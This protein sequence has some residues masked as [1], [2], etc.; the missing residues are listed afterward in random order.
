M[1]PWKEYILGVIAVSITCSIILQMIP[2]SGT[3]AVL[4]IVCG[5]LL[6]VIILQPVSGICMDDILKIQSYEP[7]SVDAYLDIGTEVSDKMRSQYIT[8]RYGAYV[9]D[10]AKAMGA[11]IVPLITVDES[12]TPVFAEIQGEIAPETRERLEKILIEDMG[13]TRENLRWIGSLESGD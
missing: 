13:I 9:L 2:E 10:K 3:K 5:V 1:E 6:T 7:E 8:D 11:E 4:H 12:Y